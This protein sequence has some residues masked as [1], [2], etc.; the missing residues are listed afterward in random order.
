MEE[1]RVREQAS[2]DR[3]R[4]VGPSDG[5]CRND[6]A[7]NASMRVDRTDTKSRAR[8]DK[9]A[10]VHLLALGFLFD[11]LFYWADS[12]EKQTPKFT[13]ISAHNPTVY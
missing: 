11:A 12:R 3:E 10:T 13:P 2:D 8:F 5:S 4:F 1:M 7:R 9:L 6:Q